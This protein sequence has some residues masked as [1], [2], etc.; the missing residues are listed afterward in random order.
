MQFIFSEIKHIFYE[1]HLLKKK[2]SSPKS[3]QVYRQ[4]YREESF[5]N[6]YYPI[7]EES[8]EI[9]NKW[10]DFNGLYEFLIL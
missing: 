7:R 10:P 9:S 8:L 5:I 3:L 1:F 6:Y 2:E 4:I